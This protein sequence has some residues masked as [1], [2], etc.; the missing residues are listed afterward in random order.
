MKFSCIVFENFFQSLLQKL[1]CWSLISAGLSSLTITFVTHL[2]LHEDVQFFFPIAVQIAYFF[3]TGI[4]YI[5]A[6][7]KD[8]RKP[9]LETK[10]W[11]VWLLRIFVILGLLSYMLSFMTY[12][13][14]PQKERMKSKVF[15]TV[16][17]I[18]IK[19]SDILYWGQL[20]AS[21]KFVSWLIDQ[22]IE[23][24]K[25][26]PV[27]IGLVYFLLIGFSSLTIIVLKLDYIYWIFT[28]R[29]VEFSFMILSNVV[30]AIIAGI[31]REIFTPECVVECV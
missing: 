8:I 7:R 3:I 19:V 18:E 20:S 30:F 5:I 23:E 1:F 26:R 4:S 9:V 17:S 10:I 27:K 6:S 28:L 21:C 15:M 12:I 11:K 16:L 14:N 29:L 25:R 13:L 22:E 2:T 24:S 31:K